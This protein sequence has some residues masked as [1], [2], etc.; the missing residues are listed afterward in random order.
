M[1]SGDRV[2]ITYIRDGSERRAS[3]ALGQQRTVQT[4]GAAIH[5]GLVGAQF[6][7]N[8]AT[9]GSGVEVLSVQEGSPAAQRDLRAGDIIKAV[10]RRPVRNLAELNELAE[11]QTILFLLVQRGDRSL[12][13]QFR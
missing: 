1:R 8:S 9:A 13:L 11:G 7:D 5:P 2:D 12:M 6:A 3:T 10:N 4:V